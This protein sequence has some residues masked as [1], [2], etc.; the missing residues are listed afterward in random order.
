MRDN[1]QLF[2]GEYGEAYQIDNCRLSCFG[3]VQLLNRREIEIFQL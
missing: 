3:A 2:E 1:S